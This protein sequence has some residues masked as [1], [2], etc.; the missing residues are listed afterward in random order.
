VFPAQQ[1]LD[2]DDRASLQV[3]FGL[4]VEQELIP[5]ERAAQAGFERQTFERVR[6]EL[7]VVEPEQV[8]AVLLG[9]GHRYVRM[10][11]QLVCV[12]PVD[13][14]GRKLSLAHFLRQQRVGPAQVDR[15]LLNFR[16]HPVER[17]AKSADFV[18]PRVDHPSVDNERIP[19][20]E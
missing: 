16:G 5:L 20:A 11:H 12:A 10:L 17:R 1:R 7:I 2:A 19:V 15:P 8:L 3:D 4:V 14:L 9:P 13:A 6:V 18:L